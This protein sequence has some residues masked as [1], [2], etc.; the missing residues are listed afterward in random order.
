MGENRENMEKIKSAVYNILAET[1]QAEEKESRKSR[2][3]K[4]EED[5]VLANIRKQMRRIRYRWRK[6]KQEK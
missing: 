4:Y 3:I 5:K 1:P 2:I 6:Q